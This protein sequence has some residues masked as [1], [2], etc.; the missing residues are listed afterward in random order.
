MALQ[1]IDSPD[2]TLSDFSAVLLSAGNKDPN[3]SFTGEK[4]VNI[5]SN[6]YASSA[7]N[8]L[9]SLLS[10]IQDDGPAYSKQAR[11]DGFS[12]RTK[13]A[14]EDRV[15]LSQPEMHVE[16]TAPDPHNLDPENGSKKQGGPDAKINAGIWLLYSLMLFVAI[17]SVFMLIRLESRTSGLEE[18]LNA[19]DADLQETI[20]SQDSEELSL[21]IKMTNNELQAIQRDLQQIKT[22]YGVLDEKYNRSVVD[23]DISQM[24]KMDVIQDSVGAIRHEI[25]ALKSELQTVRNRY[26]ASSGAGNSAPATAADNHLTV[27]LA[28]LTDKAKAE[29]V[30]EQLNEEKLYPYIQTVVVHGQQVYRL[31][32]S[33]FSNRKEAEEF[34]READEKYGMKDGWIRQS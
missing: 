34:V 20:M 24:E 22:D 23:S 33:G 29:Q 4:T 1:E 8:N 3:Q 16:N 15:I 19:Y 27:H 30:V 11:R 32:V 7:N 10:Q 12:D 28:S 21:S 5:S 6:N 9:S 13:N 18:S 26:L 2:T 25:L 31:S 14:I 17:L